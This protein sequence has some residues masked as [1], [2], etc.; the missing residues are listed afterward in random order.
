MESNVTRHTKIAHIH[1]LGWKK[2][3]PT[4]SCVH[5]YKYTLQHCAWQSR[6][7]MDQKLVTGGRVASM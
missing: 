2:N 4:A 7:E 1:T 6:Q 5:T 3:L